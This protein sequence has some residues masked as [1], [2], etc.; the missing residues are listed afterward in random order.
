MFQI[1]KGNVMTVAQIAGIMAAKRT[2]ELIPLCHPVQINKV[3]VKCQLVD[4]GSLQ[5][6]K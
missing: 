6:E 5:L 1:S 4:A 2:S 3:D